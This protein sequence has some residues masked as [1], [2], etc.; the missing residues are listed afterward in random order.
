A[1]WCVGGG[2]P[3][4]DR[5]AGAVCAG[6][7]RQNQDVVRAREVNWRKTQQAVAARARANHF[8]S[9]IEP[10]ACR[11]CRRAGRMRCGGGRIEHGYC[12]TR[13]QRRAYSGRKQE[14]PMT[15]RAGLYLSVAAVALAACL[16]APSSRV[17][18][19][20]TV[21]VG[22]SDLGGVV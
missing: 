11:L 17:E 1:I 15:L 14:L 19:Q 20:Q 9:N 6:Y 3:T 21:T 18:A 7:F 5:L 12:P 10:A 8:V 22:A 4:D 16:S 13:P 2:S